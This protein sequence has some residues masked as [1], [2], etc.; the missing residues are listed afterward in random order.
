MFEGFILVEHGVLG[1][2][3]AG[4]PAAAAAADTTPQNPPC[5]TQEDLKDCLEYFFNSIQIVLVHEYFE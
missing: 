3:K 4:A 5:S 1:A 2:V